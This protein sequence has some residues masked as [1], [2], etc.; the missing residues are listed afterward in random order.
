MS[1]QNDDEINTI[2]DDEINTITDDE[3]NS[4]T[5]ADN[6][7]TIA[8]N[9]DYT[10]YTDDTDEDQEANLQIKEIEAE[11]KGYVIE[12]EMMNSHGILIHHYLK[13]EAAS[14]TRETF[15]NRYSEQT[16]DNNNLKNI[17][18]MM[19]KLYM[20]TGYRYIV[21]VNVLTALGYRYSA[22][23]QN[24]RDAI[25]IEFKTKL[26]EFLEN[27]GDLKNTLDELSCK[28]LYVRN[29]PMQ[30]IQVLDEIS[31]VVSDKFVDDN[32]EFIKRI[33]NMKLTNEMIPELI[34]KSR[35]L[36]MDELC[37]EIEPLINLNKCLGGMMN[38]VDPRNPW[39]LNNYYKIAEP[40]TNYLNLLLSIYN[41]RGG[42]EDYFESGPGSAGNCSI[43]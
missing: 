35:E 27:P 19:E 41:E 1:G 24:E 3:I 23:F 38:Q 7:N 28:L 10:D 30:F 15:I 8:D 42:N 31:T 21:M 9:T 29:F 37:K 39:M 22:H 43:L 20:H 17:D 25:M 36:K 13:T 34:I 18:E 14:I 16:G 4:N 26:N 11:L 6:T 32:P 40:V 5:T 33:T 12:F 2:T